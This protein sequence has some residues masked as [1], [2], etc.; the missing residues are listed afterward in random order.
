MFAV[1][2][3]DNSDCEVSFARVGQDKYNAHFIRFMM[4]GMSIWTS[5]ETVIGFLE[6][7]GSDVIYI[8]S[9]KSLG[10]KSLAHA[11]YLFVSNTHKKKRI[12]T[13]SEFINLFNSAFHRSIVKYAQT[14]MIKRLLKED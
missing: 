5:F 6:H 12:Y 9:E 3:D 13:Q 7:H 1:M 4:C 14:I 11:E 10:L 2:S 8:R